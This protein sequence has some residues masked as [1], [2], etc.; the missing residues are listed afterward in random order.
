MSPKT[1]QLLHQILPPLSQP[2]PLISNACSTQPI[3]AACEYYSH[4]SFSSQYPRLE[5]NLNGNWFFGESTRG[6]TNTVY[7]LILTILGCSVSQIGIFFK[8]QL[9]NKDIIKFPSPFSVKWRKEP[10]K[11]EGISPVCA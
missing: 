7:A 11:S 5:L 9:I 10:E 3:V 6:V 8:F 4:E 1:D 2:P